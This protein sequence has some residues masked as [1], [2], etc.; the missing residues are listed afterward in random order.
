METNFFIV[1][2]SKSKNKSKGTM[3][4]KSKGKN[5]GKGKKN[6]CYYSFILLY[7]LSN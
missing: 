6:I 3:K 1:D 2:R 5:K 4:N 7:N